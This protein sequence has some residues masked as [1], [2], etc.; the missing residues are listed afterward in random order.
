MTLDHLQCVVK[1]LSND[2]VITVRWEESYLDVIYRKFVRVSRHRLGA[3]LHHVATSA[4]SKI[5]YVT[6]HDLL[7]YACCVTLCNC[8]LQLLNNQDT[9]RMFACNSIYPPAPQNFKLSCVQLMISSGSPLNVLHFSSRGVAR[10]EVGE[11]GLGTRLTH[12]HIY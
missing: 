8:H 3:K 7:L 5:I 4:V 6:Y 2:Y 1:S 9:S 12:V 11:E 10:R